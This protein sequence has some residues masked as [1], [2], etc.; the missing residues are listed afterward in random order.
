MDNADKIKSHAAHEI[1][2]TGREKG[3]M[4]GIEKVL[5]SCETSLNLV[6]SCG[7]LTINGEKLRI[8]QFN[9]SNGMLEFE[10]AVSAVKYGG[11]KQ[12]FLKRI[13]K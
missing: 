13:F 9:A 10:G 12:P 3:R 8:T 6:S 1:C 11:A 4:S 7:N 5:S 2:L